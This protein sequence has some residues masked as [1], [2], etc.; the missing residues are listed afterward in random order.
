MLLQAADCCLGQQPALSVEKLD[1]SMRSA[2]KPVL[3]LLTTDWCKYCNLQ[4]AQLKRNRD[5]QAANESFYY[6]E[7]NAE[8]KTPVT[9]HGQTYNYKAT[10]ISTGM[11]ELA[12]ALSGDKSV[13]FP[14]WVLLNKDYQVLFRYNGV[15]S[16]QQ[17]HH[18]LNAISRLQQ[19]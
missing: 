9:F 13:S 2:A 10:G 7:F 14:A 19:K 12:V 5:F 16:S 3:M 1:S 15:L 18:L 11:H 6:T 4:K 8:D 17:L